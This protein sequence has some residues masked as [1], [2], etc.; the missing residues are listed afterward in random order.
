MY[1]KSRRGWFQDKCRWPFSLL[2]QFRREQKKPGPLLLL[3]FMGTLNYLIVFVGN[4]SLL[5]F[6][7]FPNPI[8][9]K[10][11][12][13]SP[14]IYD[15]KSKVKNGVRSPKFIWASCVHLY[16]L[17]ETPQPQHPPPP[18]SHLG[19]YTRALL[20]C[21]NR[22]HLFVTP[23]LNTPICELSRLFRKFGFTCIV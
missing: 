7:C 19:S 23:C 6:R 22:R 16:S 11:V 9:I 5:K 15:Y 13:F 17:A 3:Y 20:V 4:L 12:S 21:Q 18:P 1:L 2:T 10:V 8:I 14:V